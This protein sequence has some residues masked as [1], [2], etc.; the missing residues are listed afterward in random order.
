MANKEVLRCRRCYLKKIFKELKTHQ[1]SLLMP[2]AQ[3][4]NFE[5]RQKCQLKVSSYQ[6]SNIRTFQNLSLMFTSYTQK[7]HLLFILT[8][9]WKI[10]RKDEKGNVC[11]IYLKFWLFW[12]LPGNFLALIMI[13][14][15]YFLGCK[16]EQGVLWI[17]NIVLI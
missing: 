14:N 17:D 11:A 1:S 4:K 16:S 6:E 5:F 9:I 3:K 12:I 7:T 15:F 13:I 10:S 2:A 8:I